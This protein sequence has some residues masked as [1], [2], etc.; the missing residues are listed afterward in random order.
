MD[1]TYK[2]SAS[3]RWQR[4]DQTSSTEASAAYLDRGASVLREERLELTRLLELEP[5]CTLLDVGSGVGEFLIEAAGSVDG[6]HAVGIDASEGL[7]H[8]A[9][10]RAREAGISVEF[11]LGDAQHLDFPDASFDRVNCSRVLVHLDDPAAAIKEMARVLSPGGRVGI[12][13]PDF[14]ALMID[15]DDLEVARAVRDYATAALRN[16]DI[17]RRLRRLLLGAGLE[18]VSLAGTVRPMPNLETVVDQFHLRDHLDAAVAAGVVGRDRAVKW[19][20]SLEAADLAGG[21]FM[22]AVLYR[23][24]ASKPAAAGSS[25]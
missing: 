25:D 18:I 12:S 16:P 7:L 2:S 4:V 13:E 23:A 24:V 17:G 21:V 14:D 6:I 1:D 19:W 8:M 10:S 15:S 22:G 5:G 9:T 20:R 11:R 3:G